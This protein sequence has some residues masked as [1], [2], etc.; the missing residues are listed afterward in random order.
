MGLIGGRIL[1]NSTELFFGNIQYTFFE[2][3]IGLL[4]IIVSILLIRLLMSYRN[5]KTFLKK[6]SV[7]KE[8]VTIRFDKK[9]VKPYFIKQQYIRLV[10]FYCLALVSVYIYIY[11]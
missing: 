11:I 3:V 1:S 2:K 4:I 7:S 10:V 9:S 6:Y 5:K 8:K